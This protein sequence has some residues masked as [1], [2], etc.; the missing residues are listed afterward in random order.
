[1]ALV[2]KVCGYEQKDE[3]ILKAFKQRFPDME[4]HDIPYYCGACLDNAT[5]EEYRH[6][7]DDMKPQSEGHNSNEL[8]ASVEIQ[9]A[10][11]KSD[12][13][14]G[15][16]EDVFNQAFEIY[17]KTE[18]SLFLADKEIDNKTYKILTRV[19]ENSCGHLLDRLYD[20]FLKNEY[21]SVSDYGDIE[22]W[23]G[24]FCKEEEERIK[25]EV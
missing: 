6:M 12:V 15:R 4:E 17:V 24:W 3:E 5:D 23:I 11:F 14:K 7:L 9:Y 1:M 10:N 20:Y 13:L 21:A 16:A 18:I 22:E 8:I 2:C 19:N 25:N